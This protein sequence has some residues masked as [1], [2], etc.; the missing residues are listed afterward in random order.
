MTKTGAVLADAQCADNLPA[1]RLADLADLADR[2]DRADRPGLVTTMEVAGLPVA[3]D[4][5][6]RAC[7]TDCGGERGSR[8]RALRLR[9]LTLASSALARSATWHRKRH[10][11]RAR[12][13]RFRL[14]GVRLHGRILATQIP[15]SS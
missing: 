12:H 10:R 1:L 8:L 2:A 3:V 4:R 5:R 9:L 15:G 11:N 14:R 6:D 7:V 13:R